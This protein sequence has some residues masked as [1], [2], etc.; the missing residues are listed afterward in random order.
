MAWAMLAKPSLEP[1]AAPTWGWGLG[2]PRRRAAARAR[3]GG[4]LGRVGEA[5]LGAQGRHHL[6]VGIELHA[7][8]ARVIARLG[9]AQARDTLGG[10]V[11]VSV[12]LS[13]RLHKLVDDVLGS[14]QIRI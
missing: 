7:E 4:G 2:V 11:A 1:R 14:R 13:H 3:L 9:A 6:G 10:R 8:P 5:L 12:R